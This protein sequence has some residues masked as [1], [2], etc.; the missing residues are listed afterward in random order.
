MKKALLTL[1]SAAMV[2]VAGC[3][4]QEPTATTNPASGEKDVVTVW[5]YPVH[6]DYEPE[7]KKLLESFQSKNPN[8]E[9]KYEVLSWAEGPKKFDIALNAGNPPD[10]Y[11]DKPLG[12][13]VDTGLLVDIKDMIGDKANNY[14]PVAIDYMKYEDGLYGLPLYMFLHVWGGNKALM[15]KEGIDYV[16]IQKEGWTW[17]EFKEIAQKVTKKNEKGEDQYGLVFQGSGNTS[18]ELLNHLALNNGLPYRVTKDGQFTWNDDK[19]L[20]TMKYIRELSDAGILPKETAAIDP[21]KRMELFYNNQ[22]VFMGRAI[23]YFDQMM[24]TRNADIDAGKV[25]G[26][27]VEFVLLP[28][29]HNEGEKQ[30]AVGGA[31]GYMLFKQK[32]TTDAHL[33]N[34]LKVLEHLTGDEAAQAS[35]TLGLPP[36]QKKAR[37]TYQP[38]ISKE[39]DEAAKVLA[40]YV[41]PPAGISV[42]TGAADDQFKAEVILPTVQTLLNGETTPEQALE[43]FQSK[44]KMIFGK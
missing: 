24:K 43:T 14:E 26:Q 15:E 41:L 3:S 8:I 30:V 11:F 23:P 7:L 21:K 6:N 34:S 18:D 36:V 25:Q 12:K 44:G 33:Q 22:A 37:E 16:K 10:I 17:K 39:N 4:S 32:E 19:I 35:I 9:V 13:Y 2:M 31:E 1:L 27:K 40:G 29:P 28:I 42:E 20:D 38:I 5:T